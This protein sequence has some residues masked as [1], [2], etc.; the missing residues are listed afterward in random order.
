M[1]PIELIEY[2]TWAAK[3]T[4]VTSY[5][6]KINKFITNLNTQMDQ[7]KANRLAA[8]LNEILVNSNA[9][10]LKE[11]LTNNISSKLSENL[12]ITKDLA[13]TTNELQIAWK[14][15]YLQKSKYDKLVQFQ[16]DKFN[17]ELKGTIA[18][19]TENLDTAWREALRIQGSI[20]K[21]KG[22]LL[23][24][25]LATNAAAISAYGSIISN[26]VT[27]ELMQNLEATAKGKIVGST[28]QTVQTGQG[29]RSSQQKTD[30][31][32]TFPILD[33]EETMSSILLSAKNYNKLR[34]I[35][36]VS[37]ANLV[38]LINAW[39]DSALATDFYNALSIYTSNNRL[40]LGKLLL[41][42]QALTGKDLNPASS[43]NYLILNLSNNKGKSIRILSIYSFLTKNF[44]KNLDQLDNQL[45]IFK[46]SFSPD[47]VPWWTAGSRDENDFQKKIQNAHV[48]IHLRKQELYLQ[49]LNSYL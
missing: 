35:S 4:M 38:G 20:S 8:K 26:N 1:N 23:E 42:I 7:A 44:G 24:Q 48:N 27:Q 9:D 6:Q 29:Q 2:H 11:L 45:A 28:L 33:V 40:A 5:Q 37:G 31:Q 47:A 30:V 14:E 25:F 49:T 32:I 41:A 21:F 36:L 22:N 3:T 46:F 13:V 10:A 34:D 17:P 18:A 43:I 39:N 19:V 15:Y 12:K 16:N